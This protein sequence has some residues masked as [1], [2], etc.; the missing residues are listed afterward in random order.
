MATING[1]ARENTLIGTSGPDLISGFDGNDII[2]GLAGGDEMYGGAGT[3]TL[4]YL[5][6]NFG[7]QVT[8]GTGGSLSFAGFGHAS[9]DVGN[10]FENLIGS[11]FGDVLSGNSGPN[12]I[13]GRGGADLL[14]GGPG[15]DTLTYA[16]SPSAV[17]VSLSSG[18]G[19][20]QG[21]DAEGD[22]VTGFENLVGSAFADLLIGDEFGNVIRGGA[23]A[24]LI[25]GGGGDDLLYGEANGDTFF[26]DSGADRIFGGKGNDIVQYDDSP[27][28]V[29][30]SL[31]KNGKQSSGSG[32][33]AAGDQLKQV[34]GLVGSE[35]NDSL[36][37]NNLRNY[38]NGDRGNDRIRGKDGNDWTIPPSGPRSIAGPR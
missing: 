32:G 17:V 3:D 28:G 8:L 18:A 7:V 16:N 14:D 6:S 19:L 2:E 9:L 31:K 1:N 23:G 11:A 24:D 21:G 33:D 4:S 29:A 30:I 27:A 15:V 5:T 22:D 36:G 12:V 34:E 13:E 26:S 38:L 25:G 10:G 20:P 35:F 37:G